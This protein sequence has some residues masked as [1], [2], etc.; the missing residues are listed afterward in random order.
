MTDR[1]PIGREFVVSVAT[2]PDSV[3]VPSVVE[4][5]EK[6]TVPDGVPL[7]VEVTVAVK[8]TAL[9]S[10]TDVAELVNAVVVGAGVMV[11]VAVVGVTV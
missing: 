8:V 7:L 3:S 9:S 4:P 6:V 10:A 2:P 11:K 5:E 1:V